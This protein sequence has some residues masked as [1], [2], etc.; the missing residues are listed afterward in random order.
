MKKKAY[1]SPE[2]EVVMIKIEQ[3]MLDVSSGDDGVH[4]PEDPID[5]SGEDN[6][7]RRRRNVWDEEEEDW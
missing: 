2:A 5:D 4:T 1:I 7:S 6:Y 3:L